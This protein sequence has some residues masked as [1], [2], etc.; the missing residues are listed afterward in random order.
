VV[1]VTDRDS[2]SGHDELP[3]KESNRSE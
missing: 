3:A 2:G 1:E